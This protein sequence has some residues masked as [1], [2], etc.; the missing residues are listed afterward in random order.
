[1][2]E[3]A[4]VLAVAARW[5]AEGRRMALA[6][7]VSTW[8]SA[9]R[10]VGSRMLVDADG[11]FEGSVSGG[12]IEAEV[13]ATADEVI[14][15]GRPIMRRFHVSDDRAAAVGLA[16]GGTISVFVERFD[17]HALVAR[18]LRTVESGG[19]CTTVLDLATGHRRLSVTGDPCDS[20]STGGRSEMGERTHFVE[21]WCP[22]LRL[23][24]VGAV[25]VAQTLAP[26]ASLLGY[27]VTV[28][29]PRD[30]FATPHRFPGVA[31]DTRWPDAF[32][33]EHPPTV[34][35]AVVAL[36][37]VPRLDDP[38]VAAAL[39]SPAFYIGVLGSR[40]TAEQ[41]RER[42]RSAGIRDA[43]LARIHGPIGLDIGATG[44]A[45]IAVAIAAEITAAL[46]LGSTGDHRRA[47]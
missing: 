47:A 2:N 11:A 21:S 33:A 15:D 29:D 31:L 8:G 26:F 32:F 17:D 43:D 25:H 22:R 42:L 9:P 23:V 40:A 41:R 3:A 46:R 1:M 38:A 35:T 10:A 18:L 7:V 19:E 34:R 45:E 20:T 13:L 39:A 24:I 6:T 28:V 37:H 4:D 5:I 36:T 44:P 30:A 27:D 14:A 16:C 12:C